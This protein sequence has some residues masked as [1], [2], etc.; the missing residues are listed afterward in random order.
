VKC[1]YLETHYAIG[2]GLLNLVTKVSHSGAFICYG[3][4][5]TVPIAYILKF[6][7]L[8]TGKTS[9]HVMTR[10]HAFRVQ[11]SKGTHF[12]LLQNKPTQH[13]IQLVPRFFPGGKGGQDIKL[14]THLQLLPRL[15]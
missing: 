15:K 13:T 9:A 7:L 5:W 12:S 3:H 14:T 11:I 2:S 6:K 4:F 1:T 8:T 10:L